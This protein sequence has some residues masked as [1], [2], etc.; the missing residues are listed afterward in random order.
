V[1]KG[2]RRQE[3]R[4][5]GADEKLGF[6]AAVVVHDLFRF[7]FDLL[8]LTVAFLPEAGQH[9]LSAGGPAFLETVRIPL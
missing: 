7:A 6:L 9:V 8:I 2:E 5:P 4:D 1:K 3:P